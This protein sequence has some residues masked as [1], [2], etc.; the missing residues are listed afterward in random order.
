MAGGPNAAVVP[1]WHCAEPANRTREGLET[2]SYRCTNC[3][4]QITLDFEAFGPADRPMWPPTPEERTAILESAAA[5]LWGPC[6]KL[7]E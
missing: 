5:G 1:C 4:C 2:D 7:P 6:P 3:G